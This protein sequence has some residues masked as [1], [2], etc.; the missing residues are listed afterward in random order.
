M[1][2]NLLQGMGPRLMVSVI[3]ARLI[4]AIAENESFEPWLETQKFQDVHAVLHDCVIIACGSPSEKQ[5]EKHL[6]T[7]AQSLGVQKGTSL[8]LSLMSVLADVLLKCGMPEQD[9]LHAAMRLNDCIIAIIKKL[10]VSE[11]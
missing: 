3:T 5:A 11:S 4:D 10:R 2:E 1:T 8:L 7:H 9:R 6:A